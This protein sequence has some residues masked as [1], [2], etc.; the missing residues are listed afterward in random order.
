MAVQAAEN[1]GIV[2]IW[3]PNC[4]ACSVLGCF[5]DNDRRVGFKRAGVG[6]AAHI[7]NT[8]RRAQRV[9]DVSRLLFHLG[10][11]RKSN[12]MAGGMKR[13]F[14]LLM[15]AATRFLECICTF[16]AEPGLIV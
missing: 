4:E 2:S 11:G 7:V 14:P 1:D 3:R 15:A 9:E 12:M 6:D 5:A 8:E 10:P 16:T 13:R